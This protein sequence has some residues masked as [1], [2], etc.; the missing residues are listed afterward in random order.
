ML[1]ELC[2]N[3]ARV[4]EHLMFECTLLR[5]GKPL[6]TE[7]GLERSGHGQRPAVH[8]ARRPSVRRR[9]VGHH[10]QLRRAHRQHAGRL[11]G[12]QHVGGRTDLAKDLDAFVVSPMNPHTLT[13]RPVVDSAA[14][15]YELCVPTATAMRTSSSTAGIAARWKRGTVSV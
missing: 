1:P 6:W 8:A 9:R 2:A 13:M 3:R 15:V 7:L 12:A 14:R 4:V 11:D 5:N 10:L